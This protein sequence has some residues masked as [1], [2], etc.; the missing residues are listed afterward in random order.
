M[1]LGDNL[2]KLYNCASRDQVLSPRDPKFG[3][4]VHEIF[5]KRTPLSFLAKN[6]FKM[7]YKPSWRVFSSAFSSS[8]PLSV[9]P[10][11]V[12]DVITFPPPVGPGGGR[13]R[14]HP[15]LL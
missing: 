8:P 1:F 13:A 5:A 12:N 14:G 9:S 6:H 11:M 7:I 4:V 15:C 3:M 10:Y 2:T